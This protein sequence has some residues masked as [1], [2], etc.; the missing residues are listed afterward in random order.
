MSAVSEGPIPFDVSQEENSSDPVSA[1]IFFGTS[2]ALGIASRHLLRGTRVPYTVA[3]LV[4]G[5]ALGSIGE[6]IKQ[7]F[8]QI[9]EEEIHMTR[10]FVKIMW[11][12]SIL[13]ELILSMMIICVDFAGK[14]VTEISNS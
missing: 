8:T 7:S 9:R 3:L 1:V 13:D 2:L 14:N 11:I 12:D 6:S 10:L 4:L 5:V